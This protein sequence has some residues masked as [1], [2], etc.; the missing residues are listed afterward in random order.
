M[1]RFLV[2]GNMPAGTAPVLRSLGHD[3]SDVRELAMSNSD[4]DEIF[5]LCHAEART[6][7][8]RDRDFGELVI[9]QPSHPG[10][11]LL[12]VGGLRSAAIIDR[13]VEALT[14]LGEPPISYSGRIVVIERTRV[15]IRTA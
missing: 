10:V 7:V 1:A 9:G 3:A 15:R 5:R 2:D 14:S 6:I 4:D 8:T 11:V 12:R 13:L